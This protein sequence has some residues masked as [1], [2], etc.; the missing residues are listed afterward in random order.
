MKVGVMRIAL[1]VESRTLSLPD[2]EHAMGSIS[3]PGGH[4]LGDPARFG[5]G[6]RH[7]FS[8]WKQELKVPPD[9]HAG[10]Q[11]FDAAINSLSLRVAQS[12]AVLVDRGCKATISILQQI[13]GPEDSNSLGIHLDAKS[14]H[15]ISAA[16]ASLDIDQYV[17][18]GASPQ[19]SRGA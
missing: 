12:V 6:R 4:S 7:E 5:V 11:G 18:D 14:L 2:M 19:P 8:L 1:L 13:S 9:L 3:S 15:W 10:T 17:D 16:Q